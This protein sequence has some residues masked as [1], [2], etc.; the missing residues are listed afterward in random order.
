MIDTHSHILAG[1]DDGAED[2]QET[3]EMCHIARQ[4]GISTMVATPHSFDGKY[5]CE[6]EEIKSRVCSLNEALSENDID[7]RILPGME[8]RIVAELPQHISEGRILALNEGGYVLLE[9][10]PSHIPA[11]FENL[12]KDLIER[13]FGAV[14]AHPEKNVVIQ[15]KPEYLYALI[16]EFHTWK[17]LVQITA[18]SV[19]G[20]ASFRAGR[21]ARIL[22]EHDLVH[23][24][25]T[26]A[27]SS[28][29]RIPQ[30]SQAVAVAARLV[31]EEKALKMVTQIPLAVLGKGDFPDG[32]DPRNPKRWW[33]IV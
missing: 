9:F 15:R 33:R 3:L 18:D 23:L 25:A 11:G 6:P 8:V 32:W 29:G 20:M 30:L 17:L 2:E 4:D 26:D 14:L 21:V 12:L 22:L 10:H 31:G 13:G 5:L 7:L 1:V 16:E 24:I 19:I 28:K 27:H